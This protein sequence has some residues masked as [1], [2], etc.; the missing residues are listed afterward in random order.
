MTIWPFLAA[1]MASVIT[2]Y[3][4][5]NINRQTK[6]GYYLSQTTHCLPFVFVIVMTLS[7][8][9]GEVLTGTGMEQMISLLS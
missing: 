8:G 4:K 6:V 5:S 2:S 3:L 1:Q 9:G 7:E